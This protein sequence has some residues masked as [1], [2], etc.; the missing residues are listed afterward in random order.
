MQYCSGLARAIRICWCVWNRGKGAVPNGWL[1]TA[2]YSNT[3]QTPQPSSTPFIVSLVM[4]WPSSKALSCIK[5]GPAWAVTMACEGWGP[6]FSCLKALSPQLSHG[7]LAQADLWIVKISGCYLGWSSPIN[8]FQGT[9]K[10]IG[11]NMNIVIYGLTDMQLTT[12]WLHQ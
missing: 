7:R 1:M 9:D 8:H 10:V 12:V 2:Y 6:S 4:S 11:D 5:P 3:V